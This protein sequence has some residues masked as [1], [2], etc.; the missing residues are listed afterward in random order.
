MT[1]LYTKN[2][3]H[4][5]IMELQKKE[6]NHK[7][8]LAILS[9]YIWNMKTYYWKDKC[10]QV[11]CEHLALSLHRKLLSTLINCECHPSLTNQN[12]VEYVS[13]RS[14]YY[15]QQPKKVLLQ[16]FNKQ[17]RINF[18]VRNREKDTTHVAF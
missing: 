13:W 11:T 6:L 8:S 5:V 15:R 18:A 1:S 16:V 17:C 7:T 14:F 2:W 12:V 10:F 4:L 3:I 9:V